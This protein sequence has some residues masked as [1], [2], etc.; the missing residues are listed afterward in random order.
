MRATIERRSKEKQMVLIAKVGEWKGKHMGT[1][2]G[3]PFEATRRERKTHAQRRADIAS[4]SIAQN[5]GH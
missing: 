3:K 1:V 4:K 2:K 5:R